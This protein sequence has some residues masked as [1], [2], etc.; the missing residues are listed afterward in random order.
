MDL[1]NGTQGAPGT[2]GGTTPPAGGTVTEG[3][4]QGTQNTGAE[5]TPPAG[6]Q[7]A[8]GAG[9]GGAPADWRTG[10]PDGWADKLKDVKT[11]EDALKALERG[12]GYKP[13]EKPEDITLKYPDSFKGS[14][15]EG[16][17]QNFREFCVQ[18]GITATQ[19]QKLLEWQLGANKEML[20][21]IVADGTKTLK[22]TWGSRFEENRATALKAFTALDKRMGGELSTSVA[23]RNMAND[24]TFVRA[25]HAIGK[26]LSEDTLAGGGA[27]G[28]AA[29]ESAEDT[30]KDM[31]KG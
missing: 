17:E 27:G 8:G 24:P 3:T 4:G 19:A 6:G 26:L 23:G 29:R 25:F 28:G 5:G 20:D 13:A 31:F 22:E 12:L 14:V 9:D 7:P 16:V 15:D 10:L 11:S 30:Y 2:E 18:N 1:E 21:K